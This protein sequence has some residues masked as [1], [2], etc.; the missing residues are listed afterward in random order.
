MGVF[1]EANGH[2]SYTSYIHCQNNVGF[3]SVRFGN[4]AAALPSRGLKPARLEDNSLNSGFF[5]F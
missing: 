2:G 4:T 1:D 5:W 3:V